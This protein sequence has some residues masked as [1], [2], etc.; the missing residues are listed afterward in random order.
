MG[1][2]EQFPESVK[3]FS[4]KNCGENKELEQMSDSI[5]SRS[6]LGRLRLDLHHPSPRD[7]RELFAAP[8][9]KIHLEIGFGGGE[10]L[11][12][13]ARRQPQIGIIGIEP[14][15]NGMAKLL[16]FLE[17]ELILMERIR[18]YD[19]DAV[20]VLDWLPPASIDAIDIFYPDPWPKAK[21][22]KRRFIN[23]ANLDRLARVL[24]SGGQLRFASDIVSYVEW[25]LAHCHQHEAFVTQGDERSLDAW[26]KPYPFWHSTRYEM[27]ALR[28]GRTPYYL[29]FSRL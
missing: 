17:G 16:C 7:L 26:Q 23:Q 22:H 28:E 24:K 12:D 29:T 15:M 20:L 5:K 9:E 18:L 4:D 1:L 6:A 25:T 11:L 8:V 2:L 10:H 3:R 13:N 27:K 21:H 14:F 19:D